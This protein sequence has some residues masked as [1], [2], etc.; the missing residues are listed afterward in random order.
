[1]PEIDQR[2]ILRKNR[3]LKSVGFDLIK[4]FEGY[5]FNNIQIP[6]TIGIEEL[7]SA[8]F[9]NKKGILILYGPAGT[10]IINFRN[11]GKGTCQRHFYKKLHQLYSLPKCIA[12]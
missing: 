10:G 12:V 2:E 8:D 9:I 7:K 4:T 11:A 3:N 1:M 5:S 6:K